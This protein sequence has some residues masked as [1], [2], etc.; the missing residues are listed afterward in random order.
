MF[1]AHGYNKFVNISTTS[2]HYF[3]SVSSR[4]TV[5][6]FSIALCNL[7]SCLGHVFCA[8]L[9]QDSTGNKIQLIENKK[10]NENAKHIN[11]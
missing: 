6:V 8:H 4:I 5:C 9:T 1:H 7:V 11:R 3:T 2:L 10:R